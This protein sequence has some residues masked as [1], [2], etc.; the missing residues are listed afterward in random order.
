MLAV[1]N[2]SCSMSV[3]EDSGIELS[4]GG[5]GDERRQINWPPK[6][7]PEARGD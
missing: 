4:R 2:E 7:D 6:V 5:A 1:E 3:A